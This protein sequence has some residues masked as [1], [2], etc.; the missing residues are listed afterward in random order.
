MFIGTVKNYSTHKCEFVIS[1]SLHICFTEL[2]NSLRKFI[3]INHNDLNYTKGLL[4]KMQIIRT[5]VA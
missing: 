1:C 4:T 3:P 2:C 5:L